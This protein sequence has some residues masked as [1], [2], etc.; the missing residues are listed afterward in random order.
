M[1]TNNL[2]TKVLSL[3][4]KKDTGLF[5]VE[6]FVLFNSLPLLTLRSL[7]SWIEEKMRSKVQ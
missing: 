6:N 5:K 3:D 2:S 1:L 7:D 4:L